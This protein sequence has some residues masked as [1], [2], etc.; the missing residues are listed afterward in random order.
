M[1][2]AWH[3]ELKMT[4]HDYV[5]F[6]YHR[7]VPFLI[8]FCKHYAFNVLEHLPQDIAILAVLCRENHVH[9]YVSI[10]TADMFA[11]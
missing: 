3:R 4:L 1:M 8:R 9:Y 5:Y 10:V 11:R 7:H 2:G 6:A